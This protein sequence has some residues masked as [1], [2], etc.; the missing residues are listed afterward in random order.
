MTPPAASPAQVPWWL[1]ILYTAFGA[2]LGFVLTRFKDWLDER[3]AQKRFFTAVLAE[4][5]TIDKHLKRTLKSATEYK[6]K[7]D[8]GQQE[9]LHL[10]VTF[11]RGIYDSQIGKVKD[12][13]N[14]LVIEIVEFY[15]KLSNLERVKA[16][17]TSVSF[18]LTSLSEADTHRH[19]ALVGQ[20]RSA[21]AEI[22]R[23]IN[24]LLPPLSSLIAKLERC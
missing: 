2:F 11:Q 3:Q 12:V 22:I 23:R 4:M 13:S 21:L 1:P 8:K 19:E 20:Y 15:D 17:F 24:D 10:P 5:A 16:H 18:D 9:V 7:L 6:E 14:P